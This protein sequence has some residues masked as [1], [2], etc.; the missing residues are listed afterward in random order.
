FRALR[1]RA[2]VSHPC[3]K[4]KDVARMGHP[5]LVQLQADRDLSYG[6]TCNLVMDHL[7]KEETLSLSVRRGWMR[8]VGVLMAMF[9]VACLGRATEVHTNPLN[10]DPLVREA[11]V[12]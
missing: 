12:H 8:S 6:A 9:P 11:F 10:H 7:T 1:W 3:H 2:V 5:A 4:N